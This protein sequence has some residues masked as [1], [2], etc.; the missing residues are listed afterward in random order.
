MTARRFVLAA[1]LSSTLPAL[2]AAQGNPRLV[3]GG[4][5][6]V[7][8]SW[9]DESMLGAGLVTEGRVGVNLSDKAQLELELT[10]IPFERHFES[11]VST[12]GRSVFAGVALKYD[13]TRGNV[14]PFVLA[15]YGL[16]FYR[17]TRTDPFSG[18]RTTDTTDHGYLVGLGTVVRRGNWEI[19]PEARWYM[20]SIEDG[21][22]AAM[23]LS[24]GIRASVRF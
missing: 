7:A 23:I 6:G 14:R 3:A 1:L 19:G 2:A 24:G 16:N 10:R 21:A 11:G 20:F 4:S 13:F 17:G 8:R 18:V 22:S 12:E 15:G 9:Q 5:L